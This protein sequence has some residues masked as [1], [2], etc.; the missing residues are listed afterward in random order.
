M[1]EERPQDLFQQGHGREPSTWLLAGTGVGLSIVKT[2]KR[3]RSQKRLA[4]RS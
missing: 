2:R 1:N 3:F 4:A